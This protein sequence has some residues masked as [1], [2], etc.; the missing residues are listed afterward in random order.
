MVKV[1]VIRSNCSLLIILS[2]P[3]SE[4]CLKHILSRTMIQ[5]N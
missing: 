3:D 1:R 4:G 5:V 2:V